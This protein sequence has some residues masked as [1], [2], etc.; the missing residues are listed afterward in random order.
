M[1]YKDLNTK[2]RYT[3]NELDPTLSDLEA[4][5]QGLERLFRTPKGHNPFNREYGSCLY[6]LLFRNDV[7][8]QYIPNFL[9]MDITTWE[10]RV[11]LSPMDINIY[12]I[13][14][15]TYR[16]NVTFVYNDILSGVTTD[17]NEEE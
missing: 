10:P 8:I 16:V 5:K 11:T 2:Y 15:N 13:D 7:D 17:I 14:N 6:D 9:Y 4:V 3:P 1:A 12:K